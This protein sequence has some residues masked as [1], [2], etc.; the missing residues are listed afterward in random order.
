[1]GAYC[2]WIVLG[3]R[4]ESGIER[5]LRLAVVVVV[6]RECACY[7]KSLIEARVIYQCSE[8]L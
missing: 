8:Y 2:V 1:V 7:L 6:E 5:V 4:L 3:A